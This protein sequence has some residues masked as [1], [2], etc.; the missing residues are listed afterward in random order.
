MKEILVAG[1]GNIFLGDDGFGSEAARRLLQRPAQAGVRVMDF[2]IRGLDLA[3]ALMDDYTAI[4]LV[5][6]MQR[7]GDPGTIYVIDPDLADMP[8]A[9]LVEAHSMDPVRILAF[10]SSMGAELRNVRIVGCEP[11]TFGPA[12]EGRMGLS[13]CVS[14]ALQPAIEILDWLIAGL[15]EKEALV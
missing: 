4:I 11:E 6:T 7:G 14:A 2:G 5:D 3:Y 8:A 1:I 10:A 12:G 15:K 13:R 9:S